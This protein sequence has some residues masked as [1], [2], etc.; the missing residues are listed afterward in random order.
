G[1]AAFSHPP[2]PDFRGIFDSARIS[3]PADVDCNSNGHADSDDIASGRSQDCNAN[4]NP[5]ECDIA[6][7]TSLDCNTNDTPD[8]CDIASGESADSN[9]NG[10]PDE[11]E[12]QMREICDDFE[13]GDA[14]DGTPVCWRQPVLMPSVVDVVGGDLWLRNT[15]VY[16][17]GMLSHCDPFTGHISVRALAR[18]EVPAGTE[19]SEVDLYAH[20]LL[21]P[22]EEVRGYVLEM[23]T[24]G[25]LRLVRFDVG[26]GRHELVEAETGIDLRAQLTFVQLDVRGSRMEGRA[27]RLGETM[28]VNPSVSFTDATYRDGEAG[29]AAFS[30]PPHPDF[31][32]IFDSACIF[33]P[34]PDVPLPDFIRG[35]ANDDGAADIS[36]A[37]YTLTWLYLGGAAPGCIASVDAN[38]DGRTDLSDAIY[39]LGHLFLGG[40]EPEPPFPGCGPGTLV[41]DADL[42]C[43]A[44]P[45]SCR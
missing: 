22:A 16:T 31:R 27:W 41:T 42:G 2:H 1:I 40:P 29:I 24:W 18:L 34:V 3:T 35:D 38:G 21:E 23:L 17:Y 6:E 25:K 37:I 19:Y 15:N 28:P 43:L 9:G 30:H 33:T 7:E 8:E 10:V 12:P 14:L 44:A 36:D 4:G 45:I 11:C 32:G 20:C 26:T 39:L 13:D 5:D